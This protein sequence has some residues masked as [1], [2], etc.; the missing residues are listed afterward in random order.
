ME[1]ET[2]ILGI[3]MY[4]EMVNYIVSKPYAEVN[5]L[6]YKIGADVQKNNPAMAG[7]DQKSEK[8]AQ[9]EDEKA[10]KDE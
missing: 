1:N 4:N 10:P 8:E 5:E 2:V 7:A 3:K 6:I 9:K